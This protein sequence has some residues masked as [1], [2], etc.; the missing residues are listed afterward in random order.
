MRELYTRLEEMRSN[1]LPDARSSEDR[2]C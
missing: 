1:P 2:R